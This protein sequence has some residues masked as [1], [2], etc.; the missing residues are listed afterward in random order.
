VLSESTARSL[1]TIMEGVTQRGTGTAAAL[2]R[3]FVAGKT[4]TAAKVVGGRYSNTDYNV[5]FVGFVP[6]RHP[7]FVILVVIDTPRGVPAYGGTVAAPVF[8][9]IAEA[10]LQYRGV[11]A[12]INPVPA[13]IAGMRTPPPAR[14]PASIAVVPTSIRTGDRPV[15]PD[16]RGLS[17]REALRI[18]AGLGVTMDA[19][20][21]GVVVAQTPAAGE[22]VDPAVTG[23]LQLQRT[24]ALS[25][26]GGR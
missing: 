25:A 18:A 7:A 4:G 17:L 6:S 21:D 2:D 16:L 12:S 10:A 26:G 8:K 24:A 23:R 13:I 22:L 1:T 3:Y 9:K 20:G 15:M 14:A 19:A 11:P 5:S